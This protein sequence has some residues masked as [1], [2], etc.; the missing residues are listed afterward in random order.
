MKFKSLVKD[1]M[2]QADM[3]MDKSRELYRGT[4]LFL[5]EREIREAQLITSDCGDCTVEHFSALHHKRSGKCTIQATW[6]ETVDQFFK[7]AV[8][9][10]PYHIIFSC[11]L[12][13]VYSG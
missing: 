2:D 11:I 4:K 7:D 3:I 6:E 1:C 5:V 9:G 8:Q 12:N 10:I 13:L